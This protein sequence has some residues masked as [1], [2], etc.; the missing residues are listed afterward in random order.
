MRAAIT[1][2]GLKFLIGHYFGTRWCSGGPG[3]H[4]SADAMFDGQSPGRADARKSALQIGLSEAVMSASGPIPA[5]SGPPTLQWQLLGRKATDYFRAKNVESRRSITE[6][7]F[8]S[9][10]VASR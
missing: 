1:A 6:N 4:G 9:S 8:A 2:E 3:A 10:E 5:G 7:K